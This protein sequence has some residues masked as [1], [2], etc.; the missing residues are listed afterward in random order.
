MSDALFLSA[1]GTL[2]G[3][4][5]VLWKINLRNTDKMEKRAEKIEERDEQ[6]NKL[7]FGLKEEVGE[8]RGRVGLAEEVV[9]MI[10]EL[11]ADFLAVYPKTERDKSDE[12]CE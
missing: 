6:K 12:G 11:H 9:P 5:G 10:Q 2:A 1:L 7:L 3:V 8:L 4:I